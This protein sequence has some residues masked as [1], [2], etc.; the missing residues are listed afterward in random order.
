MSAELSKNCLLQNLFRVYI[1]IC[2]HLTRTDCFHQGEQQ[3]TVTESARNSSSFGRGSARKQHFC[4]VWSTGRIVVLLVSVAEVMVH[5]ASNREAFAG[6][7]S[8]GEWRMEVNM[9]VCS[10]LGTWARRRNKK[11]LK[12]R[13]CRTRTIWDYCSCAFLTGHSFGRLGRVT[14]IL[15]GCTWHTWQDSLPCLTFSVMVSMGILRLMCIG[16]NR[17]RCPPLSLWLCI[18]S[19]KWFSRYTLVRCFIKMSENIFSVL[20][21]SLYGHVSSHPHMT[22]SVTPCLSEILMTSS[23]C[24]S[25]VATSSIPSHWRT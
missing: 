23:F 2:A 3:L 17:K 6:V 25:E 14:I 10:R 22:S 7:L 16:H 8:A 12:K 24:L 9:A 19:H 4:W 21:R 1:S 18:T 15:T 13:N 20:Y 11:Y 5:S